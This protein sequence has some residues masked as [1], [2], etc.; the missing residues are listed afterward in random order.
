M[1]G[2][3]V[4]LKEEENKDIFVKKL[5]RYILGHQLNPKQITTPHTWDI[6][7]M[8]LLSLFGPSKTL[9]LLLKLVIILIKTVVPLKLK[10]Q[11]PK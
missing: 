5:R 2:S 7:V 3:H 1:I 9:S 4:N 11:R 8:F 6:D 10:K